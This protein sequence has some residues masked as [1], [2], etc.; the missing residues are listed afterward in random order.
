MCGE[1]GHQVETAGSGAEALSL[2]MTD[3]S[4]DLLVTDYL[5]PSMTGVELIGRVRE[6]HPNMPAVIASGYTDVADQGDIPGAVRLAKPF[7]SAKLNEVLRRAS[8]ASN[9][10]KNV[11]QFVRKAAT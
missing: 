5:M 3:D 2:M 4:F 11:I 8:A 9:A 6:M 10:S 1:L 7:T